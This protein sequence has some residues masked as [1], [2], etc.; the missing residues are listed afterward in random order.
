MGNMW[1]P[2][3]KV[4]RLTPAIHK[5]VEV[6]ITDKTRKNKAKGCL[7]HYQNELNIVARPPKYTKLELFTFEDEIHKYGW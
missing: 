7:T 3:T 2:N 1:L 6:C 5:I 4:C